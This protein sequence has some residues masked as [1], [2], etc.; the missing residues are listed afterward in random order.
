MIFIEEMIIAGERVCDTW[1]VGSLTQRKFQAKDLFTRLQE[2]IMVSRQTKI[3]SSTDSNKAS[4]TNMASKTR[5]KEIGVLNNPETLLIEAT[6]FDTFS[7][8][9]RGTIE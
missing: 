7:K 1:D 5:K 8:E 6:T 3:Q 9:F 4:C 2:L